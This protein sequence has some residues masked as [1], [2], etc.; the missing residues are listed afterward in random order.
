MNL[1]EHQVVLIAANPRAGSRSRMQHL[2]ELKDW[3]EE[4]KL[5]VEIVS[6]LALAEQRASEL[7]EQGALRALVGAGGDGTLAELVNRTVPGTPLAI[8][9]AGTANLVARYVRV[10]TQIQEFGQMLLDRQTIEWDAGRANGRLFL[11][12][13]SAGFDAD[14][15]QRVHAARGSHISKLAYARPILAAALSYPFPELELNIDTDQESCS[16]LTARWAFVSNLPCYAGGLKPGVGAEGADGKLNL[17]TFRRGGLLA[18]A[19]YLPFVFC[20]IQRYL[21]DCTLRQ[22]QSVRID[23]KTQTPYELD[24]DPGGY[25]PVEIDVVPRRLSLVVPQNCLLLP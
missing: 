23:A 21:P 4:Q 5:H 15:V 20:G 25:L 3:L 14:V 2:L 9:P 12:V 10:S 1:P 13:C 11:A 22:I 16:S 24:G 17:C 7:Y 19:R 6:D 8:Y 18:A